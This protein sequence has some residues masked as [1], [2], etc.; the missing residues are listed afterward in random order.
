M[1]ISAAFDV[2][3]KNRADIEAIIGELGGLGNLL[4]L[5]PALRIPVM[6]ILTTISQH[7]DPVQKAQEI[8]RCALYYTEETKA[9]VR[10]F[11]EQYGL[12]V[13]GIVGDR[14]WQKVTELLK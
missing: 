6:N 9:S 14:T 12:A 13:D 11:Q 3:I 4:R 8:N 10:L 2:L 5:L 7:H 1:N